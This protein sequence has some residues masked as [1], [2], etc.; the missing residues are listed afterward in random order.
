MDV[1]LLSTVQ[2]RQFPNSDTAYVT[3]HH[4]GVNV[5]VLAGLGTS[6]HRLQVC[7]LG[8]SL[9]TPRQ[10]RQFQAESATHA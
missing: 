1:T 2:D 9:G 6:L 10:A 3:R 4:Q 7:G 8:T 5:R